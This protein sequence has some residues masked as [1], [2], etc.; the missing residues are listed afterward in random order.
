MVSSYSNLYRTVKSCWQQN[1]E[2]KAYRI[3]AIKYILGSAN[4][5]ELCNILYK[6]KQRLWNKMP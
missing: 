2:E 3:K 4:N 1:V 5:E 6:C